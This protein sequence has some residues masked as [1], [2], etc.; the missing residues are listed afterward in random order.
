MASDKIW[1]LYKSNNLLYRYGRLNI[2]QNFSD[3]AWVI[4]SYIGMV[5]EHFVSSIFISHKYMIV[6]Q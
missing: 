1:G 4:I 6:K 3:I 2:S 5:E